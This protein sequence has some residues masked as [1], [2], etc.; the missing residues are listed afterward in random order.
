M[1]GFVKSYPKGQNIENQNKFL[2]RKLVKKYKLVLI[3]SLR[4]YQMTKTSTRTIFQKSHVISSVNE[5]ICTLT[6]KIYVDQED[7]FLVNM[8]K[9]HFVFS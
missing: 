2:L 5:N 7:L 9:K 4:K 6:N 3:N 1:R 8:K